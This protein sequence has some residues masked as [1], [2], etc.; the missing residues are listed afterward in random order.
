MVG[1]TDD[2]E[3]DGKDEEAADLDGL[4]PQRVDQENRCPVTR[5]AASADQDQVADGI[6]PKDLVDVAPA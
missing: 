5:D 2:A 6:V 1:E 3:D 4:A